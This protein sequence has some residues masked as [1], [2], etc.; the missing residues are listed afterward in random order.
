MNK[1][2][3]PIA[4]FL[5]YTLPGLAQTMMHKEMLGRPTDHEITIQTFFNDSVEVQAEY[6]TQSGVYSLQSNWLLVPDSL[7]AEI[8]LSNLIAN[9]EYYYR[10]NYR[11]PNSSQIQHRPEYHFH[12]QRST[13]SSFTYVVQ[14][15]PHMDYNTDTALYRVCLQN[16]LEDTPDFM[17][18]LGDFLMTDKLKNAANIVPHDTIPFRCHL[19]RSYYENVTHSVPLYIAIGNHE[20]ESGWYVNGTASNIAVWDAQERTK[21]FINPAPNAFYTGDTMH[22]AFIGQR[23]NYYAWHWG[24]ALFIVLDPYW[25]TQTK[26]DSLHGWRWTLGE[27]QYNWLRTT[28]ENSSAPF[29]YVFSHQLIGGDPDGR[30]GVEFADLYEWGGN[31]IDGTPGFASNRPGW[32]KPIKDVLAENKVS[33]FFHGHD[34]LFAKQEKDCL[35][36]QETPQPSLHNFTSTSANLY[37]YLEGEIL[38]N[39][40][41]IRVTVS[42]EGTL[43]E[44]VRAYKASDENA[45]RHNK[46]ISS[47]YFIPANSPCYDSLI[48]ESPTLWN[49]L[50]ANEI[51]YP[52]PFMQ[53]T[54]IAF[55]NEK[56]Q[57]V[58]LDILNEKGQ[59]VRHLMPQTPLKQGDYT[60]VWDGKNLQGDCLPNGIYWYSINQNRCGKISLQRD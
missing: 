39:T 23:E 24:D 40:G 21:Y 50:Y 27:T 44:Y 41:H 36:Y 47:S 12:T 9:T 15:D 10:V 46:D 29:K 54:S 34:H 28:L 30:G 19:L 59:I 11:L 55:H 51:V 56:T 52:N 45:S 4:L 33:I 2:L 1:I 8:V 53:E 17:I 6:G 57:T 38:P 20:G 60:V 31:N 25:Y 35:I 16:Q 3:F 49:S 5:G 37:G 13:G 42:P 22:H 58:S 18:D 32:Y 7:P 43:V 26:P 48:L 14:A